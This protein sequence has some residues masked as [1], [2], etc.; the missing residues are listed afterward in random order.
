MVTGKL[1]TREHIDRQGDFSL[2]CFPHIIPKSKEKA[3]R[4]LKNNIGLVWS[5]KEHAIFDEKVR[6]YKEKIGY[7][8]LKKKIASG[9]EIY[10]YL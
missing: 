3:F 5:V 6:A 9:E 10:F 8:E 1:V 7:E 4:L 2:A